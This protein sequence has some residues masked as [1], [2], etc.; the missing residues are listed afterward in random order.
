MFSKGF[1]T[2]RCIEIKGEEKIDCI[3]FPQGYNRIYQ[4]RSLPYETIEQAKEAREKIIQEDL[5]QGFTIKIFTFKE[6]LSEDY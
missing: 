4:G 6:V 5:P 1:Y 2:V 3:I